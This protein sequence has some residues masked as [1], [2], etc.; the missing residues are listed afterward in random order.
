ME[1]TVDDKDQML[2]TF[3]SNP[4][5]AFIFITGYEAVKGAG[6]V[7]N[8]QLQSGI[9]YDNIKKRSIA[10]LEK[11]KAGEEVEELDVKCKT[12]KKP[13]GTYTNRKAKDR[14]LID[15]QAN[16]KFD[17]PDFQTACDELMQ[18][19]TDPKKTNQPYDQE[20]NGLYSIDD[21]ILYIRECLIVDKTV[22]TFGERPVSATEPFIALKNKIKKMLPV[23]N[24]RTFKLDGRFEKVSINHDKVLPEDE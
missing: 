11:I 2:E 21:D 24:Y 20:A 22:T 5:G 15:H 3:N 12:W 14:V 13:D 1:F 8:Y 17:S 18:G 7:A 10:M 6:E 4:S 23:S 9:S 19:M 16:Y